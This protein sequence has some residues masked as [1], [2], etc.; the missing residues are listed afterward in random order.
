MT[1]A[2]EWVAFLGARLDEDEAIARATMRW[3]GPPWAEVGREERIPERAHIARH[4]PA[5]V[6][7]EV[8]AKRAIW[9][10]CISAD[11]D[12]GPSNDLEAQALAWLILQLA[13]VYSDH[14]DYPQD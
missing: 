3:S 14:P 4:D 6:L 10:A 1:T 2:A 12:R 9:A 5:R 13:A 8:A 11:G 7:R